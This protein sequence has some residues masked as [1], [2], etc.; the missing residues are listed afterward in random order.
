V[1]TDSVNAEAPK[2][3]RLRSPN[4][5]VH[6]LES[7]LEKAELMR[8]K[9]GRHPVPSK[10]AAESL[11]HKSMNSHAKQLCASL[12]YYGLLDTSGRGDDRKFSLTEAAE[13]ILKNAPDRNDLLKK[14]ALHPKIHQEVWEHYRGELPHNDLLT[15][16]LEWDRPESQR[17]NPDA[18]NGFITRF[19][20]TLAFAGVTSGSILEPEQDAVEEEDELQL[21]VESSSDLKQVEVGD[22]IQWTSQGTDQLSTPQPVLS[23][24]EDGA[25]AFIAQ[26]KSGLP[27][28]ELAVVDS[29][30]NNEGSKSKPPQNPFFQAEKDEP[31]LGVA[32]DRITLDE[33]VVELQW[34]GEL[35]KDSVLD[36][37]DWL[38]VVVKRMKRK[39]GI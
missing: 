6:D 35:N 20:A 24:S 15:Q 19:R 29:P 11:G 8:S 23:I 10:L 38:S 7:A 32:R 16:Y 36:L 2:P 4:H 28:S 31:H 39:A 18:T 21:E 3:S 33:G 26:T 5:P 13:R 9:Y 34:P 22:F 37:E 30:S 17:F 14:A 25:W 1:S 27:M 12:G